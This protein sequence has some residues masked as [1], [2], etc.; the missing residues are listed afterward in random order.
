MVLKN[1]TLADNLLSDTVIDPKAGFPT[2]MEIKNN[3]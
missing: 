2:Y 3:E 1:L